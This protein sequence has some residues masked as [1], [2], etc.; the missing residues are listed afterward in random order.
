VWFRCVS[1]VPLVTHMSHGAQHCR[2]GRLGGTGK[3][4]IL[5]TRPGRAHR[6]LEQLANDAVRKLRFELSA[7]RSE[8][9]DP[10]TVGALRGRVE[11][12]C[13]ADPC[14]SFQQDQ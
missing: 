8:N 14:W 5:P 6:R 2:P 4:R 13:L 12:G 3:Q 7:S 10:S 1:I 9:R 11:Q